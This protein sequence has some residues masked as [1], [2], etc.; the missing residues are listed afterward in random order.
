M[1]SFSRS[2]QS[3]RENGTPFFQG[4]Q[5]GTTCRFFCARPKSHGRF[6]FFSLLE[7]YEETIGESIGVDDD[8]DDDSDE[9]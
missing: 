2:I 4:L 5:N 8:S 6:A 9:G 1:T 3:R 7:E